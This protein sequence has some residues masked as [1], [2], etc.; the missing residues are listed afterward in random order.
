M[1][2]NAKNTCLIL[3]GKEELVSYVIVITPIVFLLTQSR[4]DCKL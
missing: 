1:N 3:F 4:S 2:R